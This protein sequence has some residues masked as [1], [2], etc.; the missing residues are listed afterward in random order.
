MRRL[1]IGCALLIAVA[2]SAQESLPSVKLPAE[3]DRVLRD[4]EQAW[5][6][7]DAAGLANLFAEDGFVLAGRKPPARGREAI[8]AT[9]AKSGGPLVLRALHYATSGDVGY[10]IGVYGRDASKDVG[11]FVLALKKVRDKWLIAADIDNGNSPPPTPPAT[12]TT[13]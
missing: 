3:L 8:R 1:L 4:Y 9:Y 12:T 5:Q 10:I 7:H 6:T 11:K 2:A 13:P